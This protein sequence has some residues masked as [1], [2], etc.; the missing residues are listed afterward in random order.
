MRLKSWAG[1]Q[2]DDAVAVGEA[3]Q[4]HLG[5]VEV[6][7]DDDPPAGRGVRQRLG[8]VVGDD[9][10]LARGQ[11]VVLDHV[12]RAELVERGRGLGGVDAQPRAPRWARRP[13]PSPTWRTPCCLRAARPRPT[14]RSRRC[15]RLGR[16]RRRRRRAA[17]R[18][19]PR[20]GRRAKSRGQRG[21]GGT[22]VGVDP[23][24]LGHGGGAGVARRADQGGDGRVG[25]QGQAQRVLAGTGADDEDAHAAPSLPAG[26]SGRRRRCVS[27]AVGG[28]QHGCPTGPASRTGSPPR[29]TPAQGLPGVRVQAVQHAGRGVQRPHPPAA[30]DRR[31]GDRRAACHSRCDRPARVDPHR[32]HAVGARHV[33]DVARAPRCRRTNVH[34]SAWLTWPPMPP[35]APCRST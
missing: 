4:R 12:R 24:L 11:A 3:E 13:R 33:D 14:V 19:R 32:P 18:G 9:D 17:P 16:R 34:T 2:R 35:S 29:P 1:D 10:A 7:L 21:D 6:L 27:P 26:R 15:R 8:P 5:A 31:A 28:H 22:V 25:G 23:A 30:D 20:R